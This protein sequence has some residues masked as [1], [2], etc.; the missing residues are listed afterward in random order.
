MVT[1]LAIAAKER[2]Q[3]ELLQEIWWGWKRAVPASVDYVP[4]H[5]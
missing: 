1:R 3:E 5:H 2:T 4:Q